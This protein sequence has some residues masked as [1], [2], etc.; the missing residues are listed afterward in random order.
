ME[1]D[2]LRAEG[3]K[4]DRRE[5]TPSGMGSGV[6]L[7]LYVDSN[8]ASKN[9]NR[10]FV[11]VSFFYRTQK[12]ITLS[13]TEGEYVAMAAEI[14]ETIFVRYIWS[15]IFP[16]RDVGCTLV[17][18]DNVGAIYL[19]K[20]SATTPNSKH[21]DI[22]HHLIRKRMANGEFKVIYVPSEEQHADFLT[23]PLHQA[24]FEV[25]RNFVMNVR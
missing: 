16:N 1:G 9:T 24:A 25:Q 22:R 3:E 20:N 2:G 18:E 23:K 15:F 13:S 8:F 14:K 4:M 7:E 12:S 10:R 17:K 11:C 19:A 21:I 5:Q 6:D